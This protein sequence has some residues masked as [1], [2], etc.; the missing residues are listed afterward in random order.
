MKFTKGKNL[1][2]NWRYNVSKSIIK[3]KAAAF[4]KE[5]TRSLIIAILV[6]LAKPLMVELMA[7]IA[8]WIKAIF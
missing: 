7:L 1:T 8:E 4:F 6:E 3:K 2:Q 5:F